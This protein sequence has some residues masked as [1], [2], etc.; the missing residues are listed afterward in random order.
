MKFDRTHNSQA[1]PAVAATMSHR[2]CTRGSRAP[3]PPDYDVGKGG[4]RNLTRTLCL[5]L[6]PDRIN[7]NNISPAMVLTPMN[8]SALDDPKVREQQV[9]RIPWKRA[10]EPR[11]IARLAVYLTSDDADYVTG[12]TFTID[13]GLEMN[14]GQGA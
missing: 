13:G 3:A 1:P 2:R 12:Q 11:E 6:A 14:M 9:Q 7:V 4:L 10:P 8:Q 5:E